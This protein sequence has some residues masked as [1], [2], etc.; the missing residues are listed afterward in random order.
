MI[1][2]QVFIAGELPSFNELEAA[3]GRVAVARGTGDPTRQ[4]A[5]NAMKRKAQADCVVQILAARPPRFAPD[6]G[7]FLIEFTWQTADRR[8]DPDNLAAAKKIILDALTRTRADSVGAGVIHCDGHHCIRGFRDHF[9]PGAPRNMV[10][11][12]VTLYVQPGATP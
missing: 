11:V 8:T 12:Q 5:Y 9:R 10:G 6:A 1:A 7:P 3:R 2:A 4:N